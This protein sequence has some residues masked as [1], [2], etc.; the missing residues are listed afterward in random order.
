MLNIEPPKKKFGSD[1]S[2]FEL[3]DFL[4]YMLIFR[5]VEFPR[6]RVFSSNQIIIFHQPGLP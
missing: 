3:G 6:F 2:T 5:G 4:G 1:D